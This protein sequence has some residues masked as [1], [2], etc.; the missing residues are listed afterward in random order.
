ME[1]LEPDFI[2]EAFAVSE[3]GTEDLYDVRRVGQKKRLE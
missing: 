2:V 1:L 3:L